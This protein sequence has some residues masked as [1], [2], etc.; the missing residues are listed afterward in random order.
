MS[1]VWPRMIA[2]PSG[3][4]PWMSVTVVPDARTAWAMRSWMARSWLS[5]RRTSPTSSRA[6]RLRSNS[7]GP[8]GRTP[9]SIRPA[10]EADN[11]RPAPPGVRRV[12]LVG[13]TR[14]EQADASRQ[15]R[16]HINHRLADGDELLGEQRTQPGRRLDGPST[17]REVGREAKQPLPLP[18]VSHDT[19][20]ADDALAAVEYRCGV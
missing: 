10:W 14:V 18:P 20:L 7:T 3:P 15:R 9:R 1:P 2:A 17:R 12:G 6:I 11:R 5:N 8:S 13:T 19:Q 16:R 4:M